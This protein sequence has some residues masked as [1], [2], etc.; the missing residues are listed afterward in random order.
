MLRSSFAAVTGLLLVGG[1]SWAE[2]YKEAKITQA[3]GTVVT[4]NWKED[5]KTKAAVVYV[6][7]STKGT[8]A[9][10]KELQGQQLAKILRPGTVVDVTTEKVPAKQVGLRTPGDV[11]VI[12]E[13]KVVKK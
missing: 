13:I 1:A 2:E 8:D 12:T 11:E 6:G 7:K 9:A 5:K 10:G 4:L 3:S